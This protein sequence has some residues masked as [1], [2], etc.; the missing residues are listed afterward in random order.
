MLIPPGNLTHNPFPIVENQ[1]QVKVADFYLLKCCT[2]FALF[3]SFLFFL[4]NTT[5]N[6]LSLTSGSQPFWLMNP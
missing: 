1:V 4:S 3:C 2:V 5:Q 6:V